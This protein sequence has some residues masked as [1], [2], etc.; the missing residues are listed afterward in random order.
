[1]DRILWEQD[2]CI[3]GVGINLHPGENL[4]W[5]ENKKGPGETP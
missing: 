5:P 3:V 1:M 4:K 2:I